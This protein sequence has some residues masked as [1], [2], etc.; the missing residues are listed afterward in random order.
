MQYSY[1]L[2]F[3]T[4]KNGSML[5]LGRQKSFPAFDGLGASNYVCRNNISAVVLLMNI[6]KCCKPYLL[7]NWIS[8]K[9]RF[10]AVLHIW[11]NT[12]HISL[13]VYLLKQTFSKATISWLRF[14]PNL[15]LMLSYKWFRRGYKDSMSM[16]IVFCYKRTWNHISLGQENVLWSFPWQ[17][18]IVPKLA[19]N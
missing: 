3:S 14:L 12:A 10:F 2:R 6:I 8:R 16:L 4:T 19:A 15:K 11:C 5:K 17:P 7:S 9:S 18:C 13:V 1:K